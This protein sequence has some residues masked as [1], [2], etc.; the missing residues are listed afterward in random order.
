MKG[1][2]L[3]PDMTQA[4]YILA[5]LFKRLQGFLCVSPSPRNTRQ[6]VARL[7]AMR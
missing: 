4:S 1:W 6:T 7:T 3:N 2:R 5:L